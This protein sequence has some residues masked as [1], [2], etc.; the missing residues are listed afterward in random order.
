MPRTPRKAAGGIIYHALNRSHSKRKLFF[1][2]ADYQAFLNVLVEA[3]SRFPVQILAYCLMPNHWHLVLLPEN[4]GDLS[5]FMCWLTL[6]H[7]LRWRNAKNTVGDGA[8]YQG[9]FK[10]FPVENDNHFLTL[11]RYVERNARRANLVRSAESWQWSSAWL[12]MHPKDDTDGLLADWPVDR[13]SSWIQLLNEPENEPDRKLILTSIQRNRP[14][15]SSSWV[16]SISKR[17]SLG[18]TLRAPGRPKK[19]FA[20]KHP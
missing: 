17:L 19:Q 6:T 11:C 13:P 10:S 14:L 15:G 1:N 5:R 7:T 20:N 12:R 16:T 4:D 8:L 3:A 2:D 9:R 18:H